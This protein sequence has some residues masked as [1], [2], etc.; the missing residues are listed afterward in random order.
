MR[1]ECGCY[2]SLSAKAVLDKGNENLPKVLQLR[3]RGVVRY[4]VES[5][6]VLAK[7]I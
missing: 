2:G 3:R 5:K 4:L 1:L 7:R 6:K